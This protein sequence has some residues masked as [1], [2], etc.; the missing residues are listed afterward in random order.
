[1]EEMFR[2]LLDDPS[3]G[4]EIWE[5]VVDVCHCIGGTRLGTELVQ[6]A[7][8]ELLDLVVHVRLVLVSVI[9][10]DVWAWNIAVFKYADVLDVRI[11]LA[12]R[13]CNCL[14]EC[15]I[16]SCNVFSDRSVLLHHSGTDHFST[17]LHL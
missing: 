10:E 17:A 14:L 5:I 2:P 7:K 16:I 11:I 13:I 4:E 3:E 9:E 1:M 15:F 8:D 12:C 6:F